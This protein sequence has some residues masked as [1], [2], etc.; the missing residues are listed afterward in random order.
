MYRIIRKGGEKNMRKI[1][2]LALSLIISVFCLSTISSAYDTALRDNIILEDINSSRKYSYL[3]IVSGN[4]AEC[5]SIFRDYDNNIQSVKAVQTLEKH[6]AFGIFFAVDNASWE[7]T[8]YT[9]NLSMT[10]YKY[11]LDSGTYRL[12]TVFTVT[13]IGGQTETITVYSGETV[14]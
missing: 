2:V 13:L 10:N 11:S 7:K 14:L 9:D 1:F 5:T 6:W 8:V 3:Y 4:T 12:K